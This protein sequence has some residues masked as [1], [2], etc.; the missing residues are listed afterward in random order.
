MIAQMKKLCR[1]PEPEGKQEFFSRLGKEGFLRRQ[2]AVMNH[3]EFLAGQLCY[4][5]NGCGYCRE[6]FWFLSYGFAH[7]I[8]ET[9]RLP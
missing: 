2:P 1:A 6:F 4:I 9:I 7:S 8:Q 5:E 3:G